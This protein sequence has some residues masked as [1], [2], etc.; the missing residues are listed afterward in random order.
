MSCFHA[1]NTNLKRPERLNNPFGYI[2]SPLCQLAASETQEYILSQTPWQEE[3]SHGK[4]FGV[5]VVEDKDG[6]LGFIAAYSGL[7]ADRNDWEWFVPPVFDFQQPDGY[8]KKE[9]AA[10]S[11]LNIQLNDLLQSAEWMQAH[12]QLEEIREAQATELSEYKRYMAEAKIRRDHIREAREKDPSLPLSSEEELTKESQT[13][14]ANLKRLKKHQAEVLKQQETILEK[15]QAEAQALRQQ[16]RQRSE[17]LQRW[18]FSQFIVLNA[19]GEKRHLLDIFANTPTPIPP[20]GAGDCCAPKLLQ[21]AYLHHMRP[22]A[23]AEFWWGNSPVGILRRHLDY[24]PA[25]RG[26]CLPILTHMLQGID[27]DE[28]P[29]E[30]TT[31]I[32]PVI[33]YEDPWLM[34]INKPAGMLSVPGKSGKESVWSFVHDHCP[35]ATGPLLVHRLDMATSGLLVAAKTKQVH[36][37]LQAQFHHR[38][39]EKQYVALLESALP[40]DTPKEG[41]I[42]L[43]LCADPLDRPRQRVDETHGKPAA[44]R[45][46][47][48]DGLRITLCPKTGRTHQLRV[49]CAHPRGLNRPIKGDTLYGTPSDRLYLHAETITFT[50]PVSGK[51]M[52]FRAKAPF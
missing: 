29:W 13:M 45:Y 33:I 31:T 8:F 27:V 30:E 34:I 20:S 2:P 19:R 26:K 22:L 39:V 1:L 36:Q 46:A 41:I 52:T 28:N 47:T 48:A 40:T 18:L 15:M 9:E 23:I 44:T 25:C 35:N 5:L 11:Q 3:L 32:S 4:M 42:N 43:P 38:T 49:H 50:H 10:I 14:K 51:R 6:T 16:R 12:R 7:L 17:D 24:Y 37:D 21:Y